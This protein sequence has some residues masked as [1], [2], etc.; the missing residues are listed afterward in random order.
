MARKETNNT[1]TVDKDVEAEA[2]MSGETQEQT[3]AIATQQS[4]E[5]GAVGGDVDVRTIQPPRLQIAY[6]VGS[7]ASDFNQGDLV[8]DGEHRLV[9]KGEPLF[10]I[11]LGAFGYWKEWLTG[12]QF[13]AGMTPRQAANK[14]EVL[15][16]GGT[17]DWNMKDKNGDVQERPSFSQAMDL[18]LLIRKPEGLI[19][20]TFADI[21]E[22]GN[23]YAPAIWSVDKQAYKRVGPIVVQAQ[24]LSLRDRG[25]LSGVFEVSIEVTQKGQ[26][27]STLPK[28][29]LAD[30]N[31]DE[32]IQKIKTVFSG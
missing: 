11:V 10:V 13:D 17:Y 24:N 3:T 6:G 7:L 5:L 30:H 25:L 19:C 27:T 16:M 18:R 32:V 14:Q 28:F 26:R 22:D 8:L 15:E 2:A 23:E 29:K 20:S 31:S 12:E 4:M 1:V 9:G 21:L